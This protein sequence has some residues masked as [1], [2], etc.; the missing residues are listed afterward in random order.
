MHVTDAFEAQQQTAEFI[1]PIGF[2][3][4]QLNELLRQQRRPDRPNLSDVDVDDDC[5]F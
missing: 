2:Y 1:L 5:P 3:S 4:V